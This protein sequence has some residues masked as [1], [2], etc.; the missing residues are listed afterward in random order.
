[1]F[2]KEIQKFWK[3]WRIASGQR[4]FIERDDEVINF[5]C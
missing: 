4:L 3:K 2:I 5:H 1:M